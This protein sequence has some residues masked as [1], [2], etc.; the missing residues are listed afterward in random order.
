MPLYEYTCKSCDHHFDVRHS[1]DDKPALSCP[2]CG[3]EVRKVYHVNGVIFKGS[4]WYVT[5][6]ASKSTGASTTSTT[7]PSA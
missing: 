1:V 3:G 4:G 2:Q 6:S 5:D 7:P